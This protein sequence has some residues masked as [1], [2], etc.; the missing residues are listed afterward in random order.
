[1]PNDD[2]NAYSGAPLPSGH[3]DD[4]RD[5]E[6]RLSRRASSYDA[7]DDEPLPFPSRDRYDR[8][9]HDDGDGPS[10]AVTSVGIVGVVFSCLH[11]V[12]A[13]MLCLGGTLFAGFFVGMGQLI[14]NDPQNQN[15]PMQKAN[16]Q[17]AV[18]VCNGFGL[19]TGVV[20]VAP[21]IVYALA[22]VGLLAGGWGT[23][24]RKN[25]ARILL[26]IST[27]VVFLLDLGTTAL[28]P[29]SGGIAGVLALAYAVYAYIVLLMPQNAEEF[30]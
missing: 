18:D 13:L 23:I 24:K 3:G 9:R 8:D 29:V 10:G 25:W 26:L 7:Y 15:N 28:N 27:P 19:F 17:Q 5:E 30:A 22:A 11:I 4:D 1:M 2:D 14:A 6:R 20:V 12:G 16:A 21:A